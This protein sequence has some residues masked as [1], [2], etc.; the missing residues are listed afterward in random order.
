MMLGVS[1]KATIQLSCNLLN[2]EYIEYLM[3]REVYSDALIA[4]QLNFKIEDGRNVLHFMKDRQ[5]FLTA[6][7]NQALT[8]DEFKNFLYY[9]VYP[10]SNQQSPFES[11]LKDGY[12]PRCLELMFEILTIDSSNDYFTHMKQ[13]FFRLLDFKSPAFLTFFESCSDQLSLQVRCPWNFKKEMIIYPT[14]HTQYICQNFVEEKLKLRK[15]YFERQQQSESHDKE[16]EQSFVIHNGPYL[17]KEEQTFGL[18]YQVNPQ[19]LTENQRLSIVQQQLVSIYTYDFGWLVQG[20][21]G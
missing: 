12:S 15:G 3:K 5:E 19:S 13:H 4:E 10:N 2:L 7:K 21:V 1:S 9:V 8:K 11:L 16:L 20:K 14:H 18:K 6:Y 17:E